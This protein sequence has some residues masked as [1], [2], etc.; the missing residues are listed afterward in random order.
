MKQI[1]LKKIHVEH[2]PGSHLF[3]P[4]PVCISVFNFCIITLCNFSAFFHYESGIFNVNVYIDMK[5]EFKSLFASLIFSLLEKEFV[6]VGQSLRAC[7][8]IFPSS[9]F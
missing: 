3:P 6:R 2:A 7:A 1:S 4:L 9:L 5:T 8:E